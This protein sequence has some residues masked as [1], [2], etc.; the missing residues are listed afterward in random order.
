MVVLNDDLEAIGQE[1]VRGNYLD[2][3]HIGLDYFDAS[4]NRVAALVIGT[5]NMLKSLLKALLEPTAKLRDFETNGDYTSRLALQEEIKTLPFGA[6][7]DAY[8]DSM[9]VPRWWYTTPF[10]RP[11]VPEV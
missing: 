6:I 1:L 2:R 5:R 11:V 9:N 3:T 7:W 4:I 10:G 8:C